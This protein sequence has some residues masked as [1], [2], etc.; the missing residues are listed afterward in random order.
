MSYVYGNLRI[1]TTGK[2]DELALVP[3]VLWACDHGADFKDWFLKDWKQ[4]V[5]SPQKAT[6]G[7]QTVTIDHFWDEVTPVVEMLIELG[8]KMPELGVRVVC[9]VANSV[10][11]AKVQFT[12]EK[13]P[14]EPDWWC[15]TWFD[16]KLAEGVLR[17]EFPKKG[18]K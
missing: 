11:D 17:V 3:D 2:P 4:A 8:Q 15:P 12:V 18:D 10:T 13:Y 6:K 9:R 16:I 14:D 5:K 1:Y 7:R